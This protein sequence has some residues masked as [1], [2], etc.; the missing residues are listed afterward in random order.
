[1]AEHAYNLIRTGKI[2]ENIETSFGAP[3]K[4]VMQSLLL[5][6]QTRVSDLVAAYQQKIDV[7]NKIASLTNHED[8]PFAESNGVN[9]DT[10]P[11]KKANVPI[12]SIA[13]LNSV[14]CRLV[15]AELI[16]NVHPKTFQSP[17]DIFKEVEK[18]VTNVHFPG[19]PRGGK[20]KIEYQQKIAEGLRKVRSDSKSLKR[21]V[22]QN[23]S[24]AKRRRLFNTHTNGTGSN[25]VHEEEL[26]PALDVSSS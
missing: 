20:A 7:A 26:D 25:G 2:L 18:E 6:G 16:D 5:S 13:Q 1:M 24:A 12:K 10:H 22:E 9:G 8:D 4:D 15:E 21:K 11:A 19:G 17:A 23:G 3:A 14:L